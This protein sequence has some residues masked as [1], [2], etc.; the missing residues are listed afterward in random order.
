MSV[1][2][3]SFDEFINEGDIPA[4]EFFCDLE[5]LKTNRYISKIKIIINP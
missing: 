2:F 4:W 3:K 5:R 1:K